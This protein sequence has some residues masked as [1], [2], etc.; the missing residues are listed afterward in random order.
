[1]RTLLHHFGGKQIVDIER[2][3]EFLSL[4]D[5]QHLIDVMALH[6]LNG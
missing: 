1:M 5:Y 2:A 3:N 4:I 6:Q